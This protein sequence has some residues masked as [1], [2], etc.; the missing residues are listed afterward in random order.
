MRRHAAP[1][2]LALLLAPPALA[3]AP[4][5]QFGF[6]AAT[7]RFPH[8]GVALDA[9]GNLYGTANAGGAHGSGTV[10]RLAPDGSGGYTPT[11]LH[12]FAPGQSEYPFGG[13]TIGP[14]GALYGTTYS[15]GTSG[16][17][18]A[19]RLAPSGSGYTYST[20]HSFNG[21]TGAY[22]YLG[23]LAI[24]A[25]GNLYGTT[26][27]GGSG[28]GG[29]VG[30]VFRLAPDGL[31]NY[32]ASVLHS[33]GGPD[34]AYPY[35][36]VTLDAA[37]NLYGTT[38]DGGAN[39]VGTAWR[40]TPDGGGG[41]VHQTVSS[42]GGPAGTNPYGGLAVDAAG[43]LYGATHGG[44]TFGYGAIY[45]LAP[46][47]VGGYLQSTLLTFD[48]YNGRNPIGTLVVDAIGQ[49]F[50]TTSSGGIHGHGTMFRLAPDGVGG[51]THTILLAFDNALGSIPYGAL[52]GD[53][54][55]NLFATTYAG[56]SFGEGNLVRMPDTGFVAFNLPE[57]TTP[58]PASLALLASGLI[59][60]ARRRPQ[61]NG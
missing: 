61:A 44:G 43:T 35:S 52:A 33:F 10:W 47:G 29:A 24:D 30:A 55:G 11:V 41:Y 50:G 3:Q 49:I 28:G 26:Y 7:G 25:A 51:F 20:V 34:G 59:L 18:T 27:A 37:G 2:A 22:P 21:T 58:E 14:G 60:L 23:T 1:L 16:Y 36:G 31:G 48:G 19:W 12:S 38:Y 42:L 45:R 13:V 40:L 6:S 4:D 56:G 32:A 15:G 8:G 54:Q 53:A 39:G 17:G 9:A 46:D 57:T 5:A